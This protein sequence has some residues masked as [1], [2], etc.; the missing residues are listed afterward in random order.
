MR[1]VHQAIWVIQDVDGSVSAKVTVGRAEPLQQVPVF[2]SSG[3]A[4][5]GYPCDHG[6]GLTR[7]GVKLESRVENPAGSGN[8]SE[9][10]PFRCKTPRG[11]GPWAYQLVHFEPGQHPKF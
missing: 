7:D 2:P 4:D 9:N 6:T 11:W 3:E 10:L 8:H 5:S 1:C